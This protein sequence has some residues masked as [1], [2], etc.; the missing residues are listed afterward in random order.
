MST[1]HDRLLAVWRAAAEAGT[2]MPSEAALVAELGVSRPT[3]REELIRLESNGLLTRLPNSGTF[4]NRSALDMGLRLDHDHGG[5]GFLRHDSGRKPAG[6]RA[7]HHHVD[8]VMPLGRRLL[9]L[10]GRGGTAGGQCG[11]GGAAADQQVASV[12]GHQFLPMRVIFGAAV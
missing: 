9:R 3:V 12:D 2:P 10:R 4:P 8:G 5:A 7:N 1:T 6:A 11:R